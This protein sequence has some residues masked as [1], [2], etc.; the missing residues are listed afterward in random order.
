MDHRFSSDHRTKINRARRNCDTRRIALAEHLDAWMALY[1]ELIAR[2]GITGIQAFSRDYF[3]KL[4][5]LEPMMV[6]AFCDDQLVSAHLW[7]Q[8]ETHGYSHLVAS[9]ALGY[10]HRAAYAVYDESIS[11]FK[12]IGITQID[13]GGGAGSAQASAG[14]VQMKR[15]FSNTSAPAYLC[16][17]ILNRA[18]Y[19]QLSAGKT[20]AY[21]PLYRA[22]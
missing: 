10:A 6:G 5:A 13:F 20:G 15:G 22:P 1:N 9:N 4:C 18:V 2:H 19:N 11:Y 17:K 12:T 3:A 16:G 21:F 7:L 14:L 8:H